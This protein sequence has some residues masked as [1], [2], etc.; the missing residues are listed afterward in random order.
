MTMSLA[1]GSRLGPYEVVSPIGAGGMGEVYRAR[2]TKLGRDVALKVLPDSLAPD[3]ERLAR[4]EREA[5]LLAALNHPSI[6]HIHGF[7]DSTGTA[8]LVME[9]V[10]GPTL[11]DRIAQGPMP[12]EEAV[13]IAKQIA[14]ALEAAHE[15]GIIHR[16]LKPA[17]IKVRPDGAVKVL[18][19]GLAKAFDPPF[20][21]GAGATM[22]PTLS[23]HAT[24][25][26]IIL[27]TA[28]YM[29]PEQARGKSVDKRA[30]IWAFGCV[31]YEMLTG[32]RAFDGDDISTT[33]AAVLKTQPEWSALPSAT[34]NSLRRLLSRCLQ[35][36]PKARLRDIGEARIAIDDVLSGA[37][38]ESASTVRRAPWWRRVAIPAATLTV[39]SLVTGAVVWNAMRS[40]AAR[41]RVSRFAITLP[42]TAQLS[43]NG[44]S[45]DVALTPDG[46]RLVYVGANDSTLF[47]RP[48]DQLEATPLVRSVSIRYPFVSPNGQWVGFFDELMLKK[49]A[50]TGGP[51]VLVTRLDSAGRGATWAPDGT[52]IFATLAGLQRVSADGGAPV[53]LTRP[54][55]ALG[56]ANHWWPELLP[57]G[58]AVLY[59][60]TATTGGLDAASIAV[61]DL[62]SGRQTILLRAGSHAQYAPSGHL[63][64]AA[65][66]TLR[67]VGFDARG[68]SLV[69]T[70]IP[71]VPQ[72]LTTT[73]G[74]VEAELAR[75]GTLVYVAGD[76]GSSGRTLVWVDR[77]GHETPLA[78]PPRS[79]AVPRVSPDGTRVAVMASEQSGV[80]I[81]LWD[82]ARPTLT[83]VT[84]EAANLS[85]VWAL[86]G[87]RVVFSSNRAGGQNLFRLA[88]DGTG[89][90]E[91]LTESPNSQNP[92]AF[93][94]D[95]TRLVF[96][97]RFPKTGDDVM[98]L[99]LDGPHQVLPLVQTPFDERNGI[100]SPDGRWLAYEAND[101]G[102][103]EIY[104]RPF[105]DTTRGHWLASTNGGTQPLWARNGRELFYF[106]PDG[107]LM[108]VAASGGPAWRAGAPTKL[109]EG[110]YVVR[111]GSLPQRT[112]DIAAD[113]QRFLM[114]KA[115]GSDA[116]NAP[117]QLIVVQHFDEELKRLVP[118][119]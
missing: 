94:P 42:S 36:D 104:I 92:S 17:N 100:V 3:P 57:D 27:G 67:A 73:A 5:H 43:L 34:P 111:T 28:A 54:D 41:P 37:E 81:W 91:R 56:E 98:V 44:V 1:S 9:L 79:Y 114:M 110:R 13:P 116:T 106:A 95:G 24:Q 32:H 31:L 71:V 70:P 86:D 50:L 76:A 103:F 52:I 58:Q 53:V 19:F 48:L 46:S 61:L 84:T 64:Y 33:L 40:T 23:I 18:D 88:A 93:S 75:E 108:R 87:R 80:D 2:D 39:G 66:G 118:T 59:T 22:S 115:P 107:A 97:E 14:E 12:L 45:R 60:V 26:G 62:R 25:A 105:P 49:V 68:L 20:S 96:T 109:F 21:S 30:D 6:A 63:V 90:V 101:T 82:L 77:Q 35:K 99:A 11:A 102:R 47:V 38:E 7:E 29:S 16:D 51:S 4:F 8:A 119:K 69:G 65:A 117:P 15:Q 112:Y 72:V 10:D 113:G 55:R 89:G 78:A 83:R 74:A 85:P